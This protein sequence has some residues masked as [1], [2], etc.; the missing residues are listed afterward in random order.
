MG[1]RHR[2]CSSRPIASTPTGSPPARQ[3]QARAELRSRLGIPSEAKVALFAGKLVPFKRPMDVIAAVARLK[4]EGRDL[5][6]LVAGAGPLENEM[7]AAA[8]TTGVRIHM[9]GFCNQTVMP[10]AYAAADVLVLPSDGRETWGL[11]ANEALACGLPIVL[12]DAVGSSPDLAGDGSAGRIFPVSDVGALA[13][14]IGD[15]LDSKPSS[16]AIG[17]KSAAYSLECAA[18]GILRASAFVVDRRTRSNA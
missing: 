14:A 8:R 17:A 15:L 10:Q 12:S 9:L 2:G 6:V 18:D 16:E 5:C 3:S 11:V 13:H 1:I 4:A 7:S